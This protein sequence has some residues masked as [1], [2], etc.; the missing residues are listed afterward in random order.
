MGQMQVWESLKLVL[1]G[2]PFSK[3]KVTKL[4]MQNWVLDLEGSC[5][6]KSTGFPADL[7]WLI[8]IFLLGL[9]TLPRQH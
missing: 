2:G 9:R 6:F 4:Q 1:F 8:E 7:L 5:S 3:V